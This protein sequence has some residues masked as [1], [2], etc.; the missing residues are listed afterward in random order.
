MNARDHAIA[1][2]WGGAEA[3]FFFLVPDVWLTWVAAQGRTRDALT[4]GLSATAGALA[5]GLATRTW[6]AGRAPSASEEVLTLIPSIDAAMVRRVHGEVRGRGARA[7]LTGPL[8]G[9]PYKLYARADGLE[10]GP[11]PAFLAWSALGRWPRFALTTL[12]TA[13]FRRV[14]PARVAPWAWLGFWIAQYTAY[15]SLVGRGRSGSPRSWLSWPWRRS[16]AR[17]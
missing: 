5:G 2:A 15:F 14:V 13:G 3:T 8:R 6:A 16:A 1:A 10:G 9:I 17:G 4:A 11:L 12:I 7:L